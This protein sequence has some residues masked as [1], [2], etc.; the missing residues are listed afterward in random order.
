MALLYAKFLSRDIAVA[1][2]KKSQEEISRLSTQLQAE[3]QKVRELQDQ[4]TQ[5]LAAI[6]EIQSKLDILIAN[7]FG[8]CAVTHEDA[9]DTG[10]ATGGTTTT[11]VDSGASWTPDAYIGSWV[12]ISGGGT[13]DG[14]TRLI[15]DNDA[16]SLT[17]GT[18]F[19]L[20]LR[21][22]ISVSSFQTRCSKTCE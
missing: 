7:L 19:P 1:E 16:T 3:V 5:V 12:T 13:N 10:T 11:V 20:L 15:T 17:V 22:Q 9:A 6:A 8:A 14:E 18:A 2:A 4:Q 21:I